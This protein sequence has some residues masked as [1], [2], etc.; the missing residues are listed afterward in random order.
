MVVMENVKK[1]RKRLSPTSTTARE[2]Y[3]YSGNQ[4]A[5]PS[6]TSSLLLDDSTWDCQVAHIS[7]VEENWPRGG[8]DLS[9]E[10][11]RDVSNLLLLCSKHHHVID[12]K[13]LEFTYTVEVVQQMKQDHERKYRKAI[14]GLERI[15]DTTD[16][17]NVQYPTNLR[18]LPGFGDDADETAVNIAFMKPWID[19]I[20]QQPPAIRDLLAICLAHG[21]PGRGWKKPVRV[22]LTQIE[23]V[24]QID[25]KEI[26]RRALHLADDGLL[27][28]DV[29]EDITYF[30]LVDP[31]SGEI[32]W[33][34]FVELHT[35]AGG[36]QSI[37]RRAIGKLDFTVF[38]Q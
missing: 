20:S 3:L 19:A 36:D 9:N 25:S 4:C 32:G 15:V 16:G 31:T 1:D 29:D 38:D 23:G 13:K 12:N 18:A 10:A 37:V 2:L 7:A 28:I 14:A 17:S 5:F 21:N 24:V 27:S 6:C 33:D 22:K 8:H 35:F 26:R 30:E 34:M 11:L